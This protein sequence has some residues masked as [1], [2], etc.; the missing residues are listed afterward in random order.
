MFK[1]IFLFILLFTLSFVLYLILDIFYY[2]IKFRDQRIVT[3]KVVFQQSSW[4][5][6][7]FVL[8]PKAYAYEILSRDPNDFKD[9][10]LILFEGEQG[11]GKTMA[12]T[13]Y[14]NTLKAKY[15][16]LIICSNYGLL[17]ED[18]NLD[19]WEPIVGDLNG[20]SGLVAC[21]DEISLWFSNRNYANFPSDFLRCIVQNR[22]EHRL[23]LGTCQQINMVDKQIRRQCTEVRKCRTF[24]GCVTVVWKFRP[25]FSGDGEIIRLVSKGMYFFIQE[26]VL[27]Y[28]YDT[29]RVVE[30]LKKVGFIDNEKNRSC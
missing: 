4:F 21:F 28:Q 18:F 6:K 1:L 13:Q 8:F 11:A 16:D 7:I 17:I 9:T 30:N 10:G 27:R 24:F 20:S 14:C 12:M 29:F 22:K 5:Y 2:L 3:E 23:I 25:V 26:R 19:S 15:P